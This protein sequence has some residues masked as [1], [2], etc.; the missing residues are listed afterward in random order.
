MEENK[1]KFV[2]KWDPTLK[3]FHCPPEYGA[4]IAA[5][6]GSSPKLLWVDDIVPEPD[7]VRAM[8]STMASSVP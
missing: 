2:E 3:K 5:Y 6:R 8:S 4:A 1:A 7:R